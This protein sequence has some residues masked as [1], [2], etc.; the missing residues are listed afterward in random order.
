MGCAVLLAAVSGVTRLVLPDVEQAGEGGPPVVERSGS[1]QPNQ[2]TGPADDGAD[3]GI[4]HIDT[5][6][7]TA[8]GRLPAVIVVPTGRPP[9]DGWPAQVLI[10]GSGARSAREMLPWAEALARRGVAAISYQKR[11]EGYSIVKRDFDALADDAVEAAE[12]IRAVEEVDAD[13][14]GLTGLSEGGWIVPMAA[15]RDSRLATMIELSGPGVSPGRQLLYTV[16]SGLADAGAPHSARVAAIS[17]LST[18]LPGG[19]MDFS[20]FD[21]DP[22][23]GSAAQPLLCVYGLD[24]TTVPAEDAAAKALSARPAARSATAIR[25]MPGLGHTLTDNDGQPDAHVVEEMAGWLTDPGDRGHDI[26]G[27][28]AE[29]QHAT[30]MPANPPP[31]TSA[32]LLGSSVAVLLGFVLTRIGR[33]RTTSEERVAGRGLDRTAN[34]AGL[35]WLTNHIGLAGLLVS[36]GTGAGAVPVVISWL[37]LKLGALSAVGGVVQAVATAPQRRA[38]VP[39]Y[40]RRRVMRR[41]GAV[42]A[43]AGSLTL[44]VLGGAVRLPW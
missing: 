30:P 41:L 44:A 21:A 34:A 37:L 5:S 4:R 17:A 3:R 25:F 11:S 14:V 40:G 43:G 6:V 32:A 22:S 27:P 23:L 19:L 9:P 31:W 8:V 1:D 13:S 24:D 10:P 15:A 18:K 28:E 16:T 12:R 33:A 7:Q 42:L 36:G 20:S 26:V 35:T 29:Q 2:D 38:S 39:S